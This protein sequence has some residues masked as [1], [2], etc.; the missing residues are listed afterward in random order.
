VILIFCFVSILSSCACFSDLV[1][2]TVLIAVEAECSMHREMPAL[3]KLMNRPRIVDQNVGPLGDSSTTYRDNFNRKNEVAIRDKHPDFSYHNPKYQDDSVVQLN[4]SA[5]LLCA[6]T[7]KGTHQLPGFR[8]HMPANIRNQRKFEHSFG[9]TTH[10]IDNNLRLTQRGIGCVLGY[11]GHQPKEVKGQHNER[12]T[13]TDPR[14]TTGA[15]YG[16][17]R[18]YL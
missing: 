8:G 11:T 15:S 3:L 4:D 12:Q 10:P 7:I 1:L 9:I 2:P 17:V 13:A 14:T 16:P 18:A 6:G 5:K